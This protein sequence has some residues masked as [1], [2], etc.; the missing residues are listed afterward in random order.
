MRVYLVRHGQT[1][2]NVEGRAQGHTDVPLDAEGERQIAT[3]ESAFSRSS[4]ETVCC[5]DLRR[6]RQTADPILRATRA[7][8][9]YD[10]RLR[11]RAFGDWEG[12]EFAEIRRLAAEAQGE[13]GSLFDVRPPGGESMRDIWERIA[14]VA[15]DLFAS[16]RTTLVVSHGMATAMLLARLVRGNLETSRSFRFRNA[17]ITELRRRPEGAFTIE[18]YDDDSHVLAAADRCP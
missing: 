8:I 5:S 9:D 7:S 18:R 1:S 10:A 4:V 17:S 6:A 2:W 15:N 16:T 11:E 12:L 3:L 13:T 14:P